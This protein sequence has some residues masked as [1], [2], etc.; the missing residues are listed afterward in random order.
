MSM[1]YRNFIFYY[2][3]ILFKNI[4]IPKIEILILSNEKPF[5]HMKRFFRFIN[6]Y[7]NLKK[8]YLYSPTM[9][10]V[11]ILSIIVPNLTELY[12][13][14]KNITFTNIKWLSSLKKLEICSIECKEYFIFIK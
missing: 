12:I 11:E 10:Q 7:I 6:F 2:E 8:L 5:N 3:N 14:L 4:H 9:K 13:N 1:S